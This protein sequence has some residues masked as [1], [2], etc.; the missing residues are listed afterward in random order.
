MGFKRWLLKIAAPLV[1][2]ML[3]RRSPHRACTARWRCGPKKLIHLSLPAMDAHNLRATSVV[4]VH[5][6]GT[7][8]GILSVAAPILF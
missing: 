2:L 3:E 5:P 8:A 7:S 6:V 1:M 4:A